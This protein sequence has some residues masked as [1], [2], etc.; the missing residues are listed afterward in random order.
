MNIYQTKYIS[1]IKEVLNYDNMYEQ[2]AYDD[3]PSLKD[4]IPDIKNNIWFILENKKH[5][6]GLILLEPINNIMWNC[7]VMIYSE[8]RG[9]GS[10]EWGKQVAEYMKQNYG[11][12]KF[13][14][15]TPYESAKK[16]AERVG[17]TLVGTLSRSIKKNNE[18]MNQYLLELSV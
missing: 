13:L 16:Y 5:V 15:I 9:N 2:T 17:F 4:F 18:L 1:L 7:H 6:T 10:E 3:S 14:A 8:F 11:A 12:K